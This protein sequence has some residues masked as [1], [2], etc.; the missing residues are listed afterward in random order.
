MKKIYKS[1]F[2]S[3]ILI[4]LSLSFVRVI[5]DD[6]NKKIILTS[7][8]KT[9]TISFYDLKWWENVR[10]FPYPTTSYPYTHN[11]PALEDIY[12]LYNFIFYFVLSY[13][14]LYFIEKRVKHRKN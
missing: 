12:L 1:L 10:G 14:S 5:P 4:I 2:Y 11:S 9:L 13:I 3:V 7:Y 8:I 6:N